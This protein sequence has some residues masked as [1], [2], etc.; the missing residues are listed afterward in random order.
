MR[1]GLQYQSMHNI[2]VLLAFEFH[3]S[4]WGTIGQWVS[5]IGTTSAFLAAFYVIRRDAK[6]RRRSQ[7]RKTSLYVVTRERA[8]EEIDGKHKKWYDL[9]FK[10]LS[11]EPIYDVVFVIIDGKC[12]VDSVGRRDIL[13]SDETYEHRNSYSNV[14]WGGVDIIFRDNS[15][16]KW[17]RNVKGVLAELSHAEI[18]PY[19]DFPYRILSKAR[20][21]NFERRLRKGQ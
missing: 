7:A 10:N 13:L 12:I 20:R 21:S 11:E 2:A 15:G 4:V 19:Q 14:V 8:P 9:T 3:P 6:E 16:H 17:R 18:W 1:D 5:A